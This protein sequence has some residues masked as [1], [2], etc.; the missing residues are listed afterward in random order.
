MR[1]LVGLALAAILV[2]GCGAAAAG[3]G[4]AP[5][6]RIVYVTAPPAAQ[7]T[8]IV[9]YVTPPPSGSHVVLGTVQVHSD[10]TVYR[11]TCVGHDPYAD[12]H[13]GTAVVVRDARNAI[14]AAG[15]LAQGA[16]ERADVVFHGRTT[17]RSVSN[18]DRADGPATFHDCRMPF[19]VVVPEVDD[20]TFEFGDVARFNVPR[21]DLVAN[22]WSVDFALGE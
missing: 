12:L 13:D 14:V 10:L 17:P 11:D 9:V 15:M 21:T 4:G 22:D 20:Y 1:R 19:R 18:A 8:P 7:P 16:G 5:T 3:A 6:P 2:V